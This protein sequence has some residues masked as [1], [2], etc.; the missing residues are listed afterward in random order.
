MAFKNR[1]YAE[2]IERV[3]WT[4]VQAGAA[5]LLVESANWEYEWI[6][7]LASVLAVIKNVAAKELTGTSTV[8]ESVDDQ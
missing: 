5:Y 1:G 4:A 8:P 3:A 2:V 7:V 6:P